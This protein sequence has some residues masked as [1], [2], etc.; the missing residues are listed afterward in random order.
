MTFDDAVDK[1]PANTT[2]AK[3]QWPSADPDLPISQVLP[4]GGS[5]LTAEFGCFSSQMFTDY[6]KLWQVS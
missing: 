4:S 1:C 5:N 2:A 3:S 6:L